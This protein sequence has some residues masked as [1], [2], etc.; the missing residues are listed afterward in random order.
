MTS[1]PCLS[2][3]DVKTPCSEDYE[4]KYKIPTL[5]ELDLDSQILGEELFPGGEQAALRRLDQHMAKTVQNSD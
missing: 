2:A 4:K 1:C 5:A 3:K